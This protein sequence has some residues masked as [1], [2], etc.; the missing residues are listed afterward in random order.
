MFQELLNKYSIRS[1]ILISFIVLTITSLLIVS[2]V[3]VSNI[4]ILGDRTQELSTSAL[5]D[6]I[7]RNMLSSVN[8]NAKVIE[9][10]ISKMVSVVETIA[11]NTEVLIEDSS[12]LLTVPTY[13]DYN[14]STIPQD[15]VINS[16]YRNPISYNH[17]V[18]YIPG[19]T[20]SNLDS[21]MTPT[22]SSLI[23]DSA[24]L[25][26][27]FQSLFQ[28]AENFY[29]FYVG[30]ER[31][32][33]FR[34]YPGTVWNETRTYDHT[35][36]PW[37]IEAKNARGE[38]IITDPYK[39][40][41]SK[42]WMITIARALYYDDGSIMG[43]AAGDVLL[44]DIQEKVLSISFLE[45]GYATLFQ[46]DH[47]LIVHP[48][49]YYQ[50]EDKTTTILEVED[51]SS[52]D[53]QEVINA[54][55]NGVFEIQKGEETYFMAHAS[56]YN[57]YILLIFVPRSEVVQPLNYMEGL[58]QDNENSVTRSMITLSLLTTLLV[59]GAGFWIAQIVTQPLEKLTDLAT[60]ITE[61]ITSD[62][63][64]SEVDV[65]VDLTRNDEIGELTK[66]FSNM[67]TKLKEEQNRKK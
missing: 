5:E 4:N 54:E 35:K 20:P 34:A 56:V 29:W 43:V 8:E 27:T 2:S 66:S 18:Y 39:G 24:H 1:Q 47:T 6:Q 17:S 28:T 57:K 67:V 22:M 33:V 48:E 38:M 50:I 52:S 32:N 42:K 49:W 26:P 7:T 3:N 63:I 55:S 51:L 41:I 10:K 44:Q 62:D 30:F 53:F 31:E 23:N 65:D 40:A 25:D 21:M 60:S 19:S 59:I 46:M 37:Y 12:S 11:K 15:Y 58:I 36:R 9:R 61:N 45:S 13:F 64:F 14:L 16:D